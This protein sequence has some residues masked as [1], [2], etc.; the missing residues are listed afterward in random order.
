VCFLASQ[1]SVNLV[2]KVKE[3]V[4]DA[5]M[6]A[7]R[8]QSAKVKVQSAKV[9]VQSGRDV[10]PQALKICVSGKRRASWPI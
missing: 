3:A 7:H 2:G 10:W 4:A 9:K 5:G 1:E 8:V 6:A